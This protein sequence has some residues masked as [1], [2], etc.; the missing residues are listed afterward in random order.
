MEEGAFDLE[1]GVVSTG[2]GAFQ[3]EDIRFV[4]RRVSTSTSGACKF[5]GRTF[6]LQIVG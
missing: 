2:G 1:E 5:C 6:D 4:W 3:L